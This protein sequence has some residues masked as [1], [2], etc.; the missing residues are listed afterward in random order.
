[1][2]FDPCFIVEEM[3]RKNRL[4]KIYKTNCNVEISSYDKCI[5]NTGAIQMTTSTTL[6]STP[7]NNEDLK[8]FVVKKV[9]NQKKD[10]NRAIS[11]YSDASSV[12]EETLLKQELSRLQRQY[13]IMENE[14]K[15][16]RDQLLW[17][18]LG[19]RHKIERSQPFLSRI[20]LI[21]DILV[22]Y[23][24]PNDLLQAVLL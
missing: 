23:F 12:D 1:M 13:R 9:N 22:A 20:C 15:T 5:T 4:R 6:S 17:V 21:C 11:N 14:R 16:V 19:F 10:M 2:Q 8:D 7:I 3:Q 18:W 24:E